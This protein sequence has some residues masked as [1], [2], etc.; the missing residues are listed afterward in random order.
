MGNKSAFAYVDG[1]NLYHGIIDKRL[2]PAKGY[3]A[4]SE[5]RPWGNLLWLDLESLI[6]SYGLPNV[7]LTKIK[8]FQAP[9]FIPNSL[10]RQQIY[11]N[12]LESLSTIDSNCFY[13][14]EFK[15]IKNRCPNCFQSFYSHVEKKTDVEISTEMLTDFYTSNCEAMILI[16]GDSDQ[17][18]VIRKIKQTNPSFDIFSISPPHRKSKEISILLGQD[19]CKKINYLRLVH[20][21]LP[22]PVMYNGKVINKP[23]EYK[24]S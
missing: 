11:Q 12:A 24:I 19:N 5:D 16:G 22:D 9:S 15:R 4:F 20:N 17:L 3:S 6:N 18:P 7:K 21:Q 2:T 8:Y 10:K 1:Y 14:G 13:R 23:N